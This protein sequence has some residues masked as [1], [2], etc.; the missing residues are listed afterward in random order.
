MSSVSSQRETEE[1]GNELVAERAPGPVEW[2][3]LT[4]NRWIVAGGV[5][6]VF[7]VVVGGVLAAELVA[8]ANDDTVTRSLSAFIGGNLTL[9]TIVI[10]INQ[11]ILSREFTTPAEL[12]DRIREVVDYR[13][14][15]AERIE[16][17][18]TPAT[19]DAFLDFLVT[20]LRE[21]TVPLRDEA[22]DNAPEDARRD[23]DAFTGDLIGEAEAISATL[24]QESVDQ[25]QT[26]AVVLNAGFSVFLYDARRIQTMH[27]DSLST[28]ANDRLE[29]VVEV[30]EH[31][32]VARQYLKVLYFQRELADLSR[33][34]LYVGVP[35]LGLLLVTTWVY[36]G[37]PAPT[38]QGQSLALLV[39]V[40]G[41]VAFAPL[42]VFFA[43]VLRIATIARRT[44]SL[45]PFTIQEESP[46]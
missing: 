7:F 10:S 37:E 4:G 44:A 34:I 31:I 14:E 28:E 12:R 3:L 27:G 40:T 46:L 22:L 36:G 26:L 19:P 21:T 39:L 35:A 38:V 41:T 11:L 24:E 30:L 1:S 5:L 17:S 6:F 8:V 9:I 20:M 32:G 45:V 42:T 18:A 2:V 43:Y 25:F 16:T 23:L 13:Q 29:D 15:V 33:K